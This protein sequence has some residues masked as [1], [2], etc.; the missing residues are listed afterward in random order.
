MTPAQITNLRDYIKAD[1]ALVALADNGQDVDVAA[2]IN[3]VTAVIVE[4]PTMI[5]ERG[6]MSTLGITAGPVFMSALDD[7]SVATLASDHPLLAYQP[8]I[9]RAV[10]WLYDEG[11]D[12]GDPL[13]RAMLDALAAASVIASA[14]STAIKAV[15]EKT[16]SYPVSVGWGLVS[17]NDIAWAVRDAAGN[18]L[19][20]A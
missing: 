19:L 8:G 14:S 7:F 9:K 2:A 6:I 17:A 1:P 3:A 15:A 4:K 16:V 13:T 10:K 18:S 5:G 12:V 11:L 20:G